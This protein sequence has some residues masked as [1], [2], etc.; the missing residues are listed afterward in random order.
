MVI[1]VIGISLRR[2]P[3]SFAMGRALALVAAGAVVLNGIGYAASWLVSWNFTR[4]E[5][6]AALLSIG[7]HGFAVAAALLVE[8]GF[9][10]ATT[11]PAVVFG[12]VE[13]TTNAGLA[14]WFNGSR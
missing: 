12:I 13:M 7:M 9:P 1:L 5:R 14:K 8:A 2:T 10:T 11:L 4:G 3:R 6:I